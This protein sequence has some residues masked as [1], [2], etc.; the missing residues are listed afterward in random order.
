VPILYIDLN[1]QH[2][3]CHRSKRPIPGPYSGSPVHALIGIFYG[4]TDSVAPFSALVREARAD[5]NANT[6]IQARLD[7]LVRECQD[8][9]QPSQ[10]AL[11]MRLPNYGVALFGNGM[12]VSTCWV[13]LWWA[14]LTLGS[15]LRALP[16]IALL[17]EADHAF[18]DID[19]FGA[20][21]A[22]IIFANYHEDERHFL[23]QACL[24]RLVGCSSGGLDSLSEPC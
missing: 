15:L 10:S 19:R 24:F 4:A 13:Q 23:S 16:I 12:L 11:D 18:V 20:H 22:A 2:V 14:G 6:N 7:D 9:F 1:L 5:S 3:V 21:C 8:V 17:L